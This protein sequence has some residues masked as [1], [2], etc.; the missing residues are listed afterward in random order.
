MAGMKELEELLSE[1]NARTRALAESLPKV[2]DARD[3]SPKSKIPYKVLCYREGMIWRVEELSRSACACFERGDIV[4]GISL[5]RSVVEC[6]AAIWF[7]H[8][9]LK[10]K[11]KH[12]VDENFDAKVMSLLM[13]HRGV[14]DGM[15][16]AIHVND[17]LDEA[18]K[19]F[20]GFM[21]VYDQMSEYAHPN[22]A[23]TQAVYSKIDRENL[24]THFGRGFKENHHI[25]AVRGLH[26]LTG[27]LLLFE[28]AYNRIA[29]VMPDFIKACETALERRGG[30]KSAS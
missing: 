13:G 16:K 12:G 14:V 3:T 24:Q 28:W 22:W 15:P 25:H 29:D 20:P 9:L 27:A 17:F 23:G 6:A 11:I 21:E 19:A 7:L 2:V 18:D 10:R 5:A 8:G 1:A 30:A 4:A 26:G